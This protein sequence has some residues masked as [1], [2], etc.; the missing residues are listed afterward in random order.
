MTTTHALPPRRRASLALIVMVAA[1]LGALLT[2]AAL[3]STSSP[4][5]GYVAE[6]DAAMS[7]M[8]AEM[9][10]KP[11]G[12]A[13]RDFVSMMAPHHQGAIDMAQTEL[14]YGHNEQLRRL[15]QEIIVDQQQEIVA[16]RMAVGEPPPSP[17]A[18]PDQPPDLIARSPLATS[19]YR[20]IC[21]WIR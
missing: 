16:M 4:Q 9:A 3:G 2:A 5:A 17:T 7:R 13:D 18:A 8:M 19:I 15:S 20:H 14:R 6:N 10:I 21:R 12:D 11:S 1:V